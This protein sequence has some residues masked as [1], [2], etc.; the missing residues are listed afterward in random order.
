MKTSPLQHSNHHFAHTGRKFSLDVFHDP[1]QIQTQVPS[2][3]PVSPTAPYLELAPTIC[4]AKSAPSSR[5]SERPASTGSLDGGGHSLKPS[6]PPIIDFSDERV[7]LTP[8]PQHQILPFQSRPEEIKV[9]VQFNA[10]SFDRIRA[11]FPVE[12]ESLME[13]WTN[14]TR[15]EMSDFELIARTKRVLLKEESLWSLWCDIVGLDASFD[16]EDTARAEHA[17]DDD[18]TQKSDHEPL[19]CSVVLESI[20]EDGTVA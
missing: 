12:N 20:P 17:D 8:L 5:S 13:I 2:S 4:V 7:S 3:P 19:S 15:R 6:T 1:N 11:R 16:I 9:L 14:T 10:T 18:D